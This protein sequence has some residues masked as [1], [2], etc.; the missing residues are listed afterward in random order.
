MTA[1]RRAREPSLHRRRRAHV[2]RGVFGSTSRMSCD[3]CGGSHA[4]TGPNRSSCSRRNDREPGRARAGA[5]GRARDGGRTATPRRSRAGG[6]HLE[7][8]VLDASSGSARA[9]TRWSVAT[10]RAAPPRRGLRTICLRRA[11]EPPSSSPLRCRA[12]GHRTASRLAAYRAGVPRREQRRDIERRLV[13]ASF[14][15][16]TATDALELGIDIGL[17]DCAISVGFPGT[18]ASLR[19]QWGAQDAPDEGSR[20]SSRATTRSTSSSPANR[21]AALAPC[22][23]RRIPRPTPTEDPRSSRS[24]ARLRGAIDGRTKRRSGRRRFVAPPS[25]LSSTHACRVRLKGRDYPRSAR[26]AAP[27]GDAEAFN[28][29]GS[30]DRV[31][32][33]LVERDRAYSTVYEEP[34]T[35]TSRSS[36]SS[37]RS[38]SS[39]RVALVT[40]ASVDWYT[41][42]KKETETAIEK[43]SGSSDGSR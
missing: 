36:T 1:G 9:A 2:Y 31:A 40:P 19:Q 35:C 13:E 18:V 26:V 33:R 41:Q 10:P 24:C 7:P 42:A 30:S 20:S 22:R 17:L 21:R 39:I 8:A 27:S 3:A 25:F 4:C 15:G 16:V 43:P 6:R 37:S 38:T 11:A 14:L 29:R 34:S 5:Y 23:R 28:R 32:A 12:C